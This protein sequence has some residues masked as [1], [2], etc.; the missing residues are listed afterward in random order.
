MIGQG[1]KT[2][3]KVLDKGRLT[4]GAASVGAAQKLLDMSV[5]HARQRVQFG[6]PIGEF[7]MIQAM[8]ADMATEVYAGRQMLY[9]AAAL[10]DEGR[11]ITREASMVKLFCTEMVGR[12]ADKAIQI[13]GGMGYMKDLP[14]EM[15]YRDVRLYRI[16]EGTSEIQ[17]LV[18]AR[19]LLSEREE[20]RRRGSG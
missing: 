10:R 18:I 11:R 13:H 16:F 19:D 7:Q 20:G 9:H 8:L 6:K 1:F 14:V 2:A 12:V 17:R 3:M 5:E 15:Y 4:M